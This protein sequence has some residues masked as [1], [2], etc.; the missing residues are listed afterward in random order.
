MNVQ[1]SPDLTLDTDFP[2]GNA[3]FLEYDD[4]D[5]A[6]PRLR[7]AP[8]L[9]DTE[10]YWFYWYCRISGRRLPRAILL[11]FADNHAIGDLGPAVSCDDGESWDW[12]G[13]AAVRGNTAIVSIPAGTEVLRLSVSIPYTSRE[14]EAF[15]RR[16]ATPGLRVL[17]RD[18]ITVIESDS[19]VVEQE[20]A[21]EA[22]VLLCTARHHACE[23]LANYVLEGML[24]A[25]AAGAVSKSGGPSIL[26]VPFVDEAGVEAGDQGKNRAPRDHN[27]DYGPSPLYDGVKTVQSCVASLSGPVIGFDLHCPYLCGGETNNHIYCVGT[28]FAE[29]DALVREFA[30]I[31]STMESS[32]F[33][34]RPEPYLPHGESWNSRPL[35]A[36]DTCARWLAKQ[37]SV[38]FAT[39]IE[40]PYSLVDGV[41]VQAEKAVAFGKV[42]YAAVCR[43][44]KP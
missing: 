30:H 41:T 2:G 19:R 31:L 29:N 21:E 12:T 43:F 7:L 14:L 20:N 1:L 28:P 38:L 17:Q 4:A 24:A 27:R 36:H 35:E 33:P 39:T 42:L 26:A 9:R 3:R 25:A 23:A 44:L 40:I 6:C 10:G 22:P 32:P 37:D 15:L 11:D 34:I 13:A 5:P 8:D 16:N 18:P